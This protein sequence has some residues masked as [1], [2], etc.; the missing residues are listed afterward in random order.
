M[1]AGAVG[2]KAFEPI[3]MEAAKEQVPDLSKER[4]V[5][6]E[7]GVEAA[8]GRCRCVGVGVDA[9][10]PSGLD[11]NQARYEEAGTFRTARVFY[12]RRR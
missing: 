2:L 4:L 1:R 11:P 3:A 9:V 12:V 7:D 5:V 6:Y 8:A 10:P